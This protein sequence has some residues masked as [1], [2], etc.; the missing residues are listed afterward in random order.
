MMCYPTE[1]QK[2]R[3]IAIFWVVF[4]LGACI[5]SAV[6]MALSWDAAHD[7][8]L[9][10]G[11]YAAFIAI[12]FFGGCCAGLLKNPAS[13]KRSDGSPVTVTKA[14]TWRIEITGLYKLLRTDPWC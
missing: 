1:A 5:G 6:A 9:G 14:T 8:S 7:S 4:N 3:F 13:L 10:N 11:A 2:G 12:T